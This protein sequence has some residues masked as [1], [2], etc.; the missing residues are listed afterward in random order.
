MLRSA[1][2]QKHRILI[3][4]CGLAGLRI[5]EALSVRASDLN[6]ETMMLRVLGKGE[7]VR[8]V[9]ISNELWGI[10]SLAV[11]ESFCND[12]APLVELHERA[13]R[14]AVTV[15]GQRARLSRS[16]SSHDLR[17]TFATELYNKTLDIR[18]VQEILGHSSVETTQIYTGIAQKRMRDAIAVL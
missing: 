17:A 1:M 18:I 7:K 4:L 10:I 14:K 16:V 11:V 6:V 15:C 5:H 9:P 12:N 13:A 8:N 3:A 2:L